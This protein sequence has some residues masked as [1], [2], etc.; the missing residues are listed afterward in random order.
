MEFLYFLCKTFIK[1]P[2]DPF[3]T[4]MNP[5]HKLFFFF[6]WLNENNAKYELAKNHAYIIGGF[7]NPEAVKKLLGVGE[8]TSSDEDL[9]GTLDL[10]SKSPSKTPNKSDQANNSSMK[11]RKI[12]RKW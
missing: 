10:I 9:E 7:I 6:H 12:I 8:I 1:L 2:D 5:V 4:E 3:I 11:K